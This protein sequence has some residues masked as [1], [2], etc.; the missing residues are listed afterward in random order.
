[1]SETA[2][3]SLDVYRDHR[4]DLGSQRYVYAVVSRRSRG[5][6]IGINLN[7]DKLCNFDCVYCQVDRTTPGGPGD[8]DLG[9]LTAELEATLNL[10]TSSELFELERFRTTPPALRRLN[11]IAFAGDG[12]PTTCPEFGRAVEIAAG[13]LRQRGLNT[14]KVVLITNATMFHR[15]AVRQALEALYA[16]HGEV[17]AKL[18]AGTEAYYH[19]IERTTIPFRRILDNITAL[20]KDHAVVIQALFLRFDGQ[21]PSTVEQE[22]F[23]DRLHEIVAAGGKID[24]VQVYTVARRPAEASVTALSDAEIDALAELVRR[25]TGLAVEAFYSR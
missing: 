12:E 13:A 23:C 3:R 18:D 19:Q 10:V 7:P 1:M 21:P 5:V 4:R 22:A 11:D 6:S 25:R 16:Q 20:A 9:Q 2:R 15:P 14:V 17:W 8:V 24:R